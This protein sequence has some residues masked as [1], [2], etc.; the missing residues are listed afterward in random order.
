MSRLRF[1]SLD[2]TAGWHAPVDMTKGQNNGLNV[3]VSCPR[4]SVVRRTVH[5]GGF[6]SHPAD[7]EVGRFFLFE[8]DYNKALAG[9]K[10]M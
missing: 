3:T 8:T 7:S 1:A 4:Q 9:T 6:G 5:A 2:M 10:G